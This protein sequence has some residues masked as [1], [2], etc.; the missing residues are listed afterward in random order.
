MSRSNEEPVVPMSKLAV[1]AAARALLEAANALHEDPRTARR[2][3]VLAALKTY[4]AAETRLDDAIDEYM[5]MAR[6]NGA[7]R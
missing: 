2:E 1:V 6:N 7:K 3:A 4:D 5:A